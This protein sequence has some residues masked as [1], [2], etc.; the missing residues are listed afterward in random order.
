MT[1][2][3]IEIKFRTW[4][5]YSGCLINT[6][7]TV[8]PNPNTTN[9]LDRAL[10]L[11]S[12]VEVGAKFGLVQS[13][14]G[15]GM[16]AGLE[17]K[18]AVFPKDLKAQGSL[19]EML[20]Q[21]RTSVPPT[22][23]PPLVELLEAFRKA[24]WTLDSAGVLRSLK[25]GSRVSGEEIRNEFTPFGGKVS[26]TG[27]TWEKAKGWAIL[28]NKLFN[29]PATFH[30]Q[31]ES[32]KK[33]LL[34]SNKTGETEAYKATTGVENP[35]VLSVGE[36]MTPEQDLAWCVYHAHS[37]NGP[38]PARDCLKRSNPN[39]DASWPSR[40][41]RTLG[42]KE[43][44]KWKDTDGEDS[45][46]DRTRVLAMKSGLWDESLFVGSNVLMPKNL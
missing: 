7:F 1:N 33:S 38:A 24:G 27:H 16:S 11:T 4:K 40:L 22:S 17:H 9:H 28:F 39:S 2:K 21:I 18:I 15:A 13:Y 23:C 43:F 36:N 45:R 26:R 19:W 31:I 41:I 32:A 35:V 29:H 10:Y 34:M 12:L 42:L 8:Y 14:D 44:G 37:V 25:T 30:C 5:E 3:E 20:N 6:E 46:Y